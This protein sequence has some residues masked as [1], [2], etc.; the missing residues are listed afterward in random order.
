LRSPR[1]VTLTQRNQLVALPNKDGSSQ[2]GIDAIGEERTAPWDEDFAGHAV[3]LSTADNQAVALV[4]I[5]F[6]PIAMQQISSRFDNRT[7]VRNYMI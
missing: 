4:S 7:V 6:S 1:Q 3:A 5:N 2:F